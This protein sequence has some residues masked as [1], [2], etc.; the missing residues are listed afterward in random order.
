MTEYR[1]KTSK[2]TAPITIEVDY[3]SKPE[4]NEL[5]KELLWS[6]RQFYLPDIEEATTEEYKQYQAESEHAWSA[7][8]AAFGN[9][10]GLKSILRDDSEGALDRIT[11]QLIEWTKDL[12][13]PQGGIDGKW[14]AQT[15][16]DCCDTTALFMC[17]RLWPFTKIIR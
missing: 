6:Y 13:W 14:T 3:L 1:Q 16:G 4:I 17:D 11:D 9:K 2:H 15:A 5:V 7:L 12:D 8:E 10:P